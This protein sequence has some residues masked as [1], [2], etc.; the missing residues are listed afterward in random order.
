[1]TSRW[2]ANSSP[3]IL[4]GK[5]EQLELLAELA[6]ELVVPR[7]VLQEVTVRKDEA[8]LAHFLESSSAVRIEADCAILPEVLVWDLG[9]GESQ[10]LSVAARLSA[11]RVVLDDQ[12]ARR[13][14]IALNLRVI[15]SLGVVV[16][17]KR[18]GLI[19]QAG[20]IVER[21]RRAG[22]YADDELVRRALAQA[23]E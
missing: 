17:A 18:R 12:E 22:L 9:R 2:V 19:A 21:L 10:A 5:A 4:L 13:C 6:G 7:S 14:A 8:P 20:P 1:M 16:Q 3:L 15:A 23:G 11:R